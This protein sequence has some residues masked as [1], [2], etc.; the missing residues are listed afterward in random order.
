MV[1][2]SIDVHGDGVN[3]VTQGH[4]VEKYVNK[5]LVSRKFVS[6][7]MMKKM[8]RNVAAPKVGRGVASK[9]PK[10]T[11]I[12]TPQVVQTAPPVQATSAPLVVEQGTSL[13]QSI[14]NG[15]GAGIGLAAGEDLTQGLLGAFSDMF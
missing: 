9:S 3:G 2:S 12:G 4:I 8:V 14:K 7:A 10:K 15:F 6:N 1:V 5:V 13:G 11:Q